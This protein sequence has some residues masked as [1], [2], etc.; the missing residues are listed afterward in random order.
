MRN[1]VYF[2]NMTDFLIQD[3]RQ[4]IV[5]KYLVDIFLLEYVYI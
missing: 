4:T 5:P 1:Y 3:L 2:K